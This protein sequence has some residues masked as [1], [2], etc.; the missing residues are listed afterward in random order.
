MF[1]WCSNAY[2]RYL[3][4]QSR[5]FNALVIYDVL[6]TWNLL[7]YIAT[8]NNVK[9]SKKMSHISLL[10]VKGICNNFSGMTAIFCF[11][12]IKKLFPAPILLINLL[13]IVLKKYFWPFST[14]TRTMPKSKCIL[15]F[16]VKNC[17]NKKIEI[18]SFCH[19]AFSWKI[20][21]MLQKYVDP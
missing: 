17:I 13:L 4:K 16:H 21:M 9:T 18:V 11:I 2:D 10:F 20:C 6:F 12:K 14:I 15:R 5:K 8:K 7:S 19:I 3:T 1:S